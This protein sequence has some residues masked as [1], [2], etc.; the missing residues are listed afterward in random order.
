MSLSAPGAKLVYAKSISKAIGIVTYLGEKLMAKPIHD[1]FLSAFCMQ[2]ALPLNATRPLFELFPGLA[3]HI[4]HV[5]L[6][7]LPTPIV[8]LDTVASKY[9]AHALFCK[10]DGKTNIALFGGNKVRKLEFLLADALRRHATTVVTI[11]GAGSNHALATAVYAKQLGLKAHLLLTPQLRTNYARRN[12][13]MDYYYGAQ[14][15]YFETKEARNIEIVNLMTSVLNYYIPAGGSNEYGALGYVNAALEL[16]QQC[17]AGVM[18][19]PEYIYI[20]CGSCGTLAGLLVGSKI[21]AMPGKIIGVIDDNSEPLEHTR[22]KILLLANNTL[23][24]LRSFGA[25]ISDSTVTEKDIELRAGVSEYAEVTAD[26]R[27]AL[28]IMR[29]YEGIQLDTTYSG[30]AFA[31]LLHDLATQEHLRQSTVLFWKTYSDGSYTDIVS[32]VDY[33]KLPAGVHQY[34]ECDLQPNDDQGC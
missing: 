33:K 31:A 9:G 1:F 26:T 10:D 27:D 24:Y 15:D 7:V 11:G 34:F 18:P 20:P 30:K 32:T 17:E 4:A 16:K 28:K 3:E 23:A 6:A 12:L 19:Y 14:I 21:A 25:D 2:L 29:E 22:E 8:K 13:L 5:P